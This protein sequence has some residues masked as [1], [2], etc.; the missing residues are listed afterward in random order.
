L[1]PEVPTAVAKALADKPA[2]G[3]TGVAFADELEHPSAKM[4]RRPVSYVLAACY[5]LSWGGL[6]LGVVPKFQRIFQTMLKGRPLPKLTQFV[7]TGAPW[8][9]LLA[10]VVLALLV[11][12]KDRMKR[13]PP[14]WLFF[15]ILVFGVWLVVTG[16]FLPIMR[17]QNG[18]Q[19]QS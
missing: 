15:S 13:R 5:L 17:I 3:C 19:S 14:N 6:A 8:C 9:L 2:S 12:G 11:L 7:L 1:S 16:L 4:K 18:L 10:A